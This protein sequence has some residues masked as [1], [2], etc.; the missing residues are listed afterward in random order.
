M[1][2][3][4]AAVLEIYFNFFILKV[5]SFHS[6]L[7]FSP[8]ILQVFSSVS[9]FFIFFLFQTSYIFPPSPLLFSKYYHFLVFSLFF[10][11]SSIFC[12]GI[13]PIYLL[14]VNVLISHSKTSPTLYVSIYRLF[15]IF[16]MS[17]FVFSYPFNI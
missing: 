16:R 9:I 3:Y 8:Y 4:P 5:Q 1:D 10:H 17:S 6:V 13:P 12:I 11:I 7:N 15:T 14:I 2:V